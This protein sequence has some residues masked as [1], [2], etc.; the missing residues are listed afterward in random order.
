MTLATYVADGCILRHQWEGGG[1]WSC[2]A[3][4]SQHGE[5][6]RILRW[7]WVCGVIGESLS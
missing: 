6:A 7:E 4:M 5:N 3:W 1:P 2:G